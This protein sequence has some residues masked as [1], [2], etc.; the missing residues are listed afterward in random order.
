MPALARGQASS[1]ANPALDLFTQINGVLVDVAVLE[2]QVFDV[3]D[4]G[5]AQ[6]PVQVHPTTPGARAPVNVTTLCPAGDKLST[7]HFVARWTPSIDEAIGTHEIQWFF[8]LT[9]TA[10]EQTFRE[11]FEVLVAVAGFSSTGYASVSDLRD[12]GVS[13][14]DASDRRLQ[15]QLSLASRY[16]ERVTGRF[17]EPRAQTLKLDGSGGRVLPLGQPIIGVDQVMIDS[18][19]F[20]PGDL[21]VETSLFRVYNRHLT[22]GLFQPD[23][24]DNPKLEFFHGED[25]AGVHFEPM[26]GLSLSSLVWPVGQQ[27]VTVRGVFGY[28]EPDGSPTGR[29]PELIRH[30]TKLLVMRELPRLADRDRREDAQR[31]WRLTS[32]HTR[33]QG[34]NLEPLKLHGDFTGDPEIDNILVAFCRPPDLGAA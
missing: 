28:T 24:R 8:R 13:V 33:D 23:D 1:C 7:G 3:S 4:P 22:E 18:G 21:D 6:S 17:F 20:R 27:N 30:A 25:L 26:R 15:Q 10:P 29:T 34:Y 2:F 31:R 11:E 19:P 16:I 5:K 9:Q 32:E 12:E 14:N